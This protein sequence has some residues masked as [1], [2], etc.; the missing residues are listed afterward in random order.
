MLGGL[1]DIVPLS[2]GAL[3]SV[4]LGDRELARCVASLVRCRAGEL[5]GCMQP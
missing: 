4:G 2:C 1:S 5:S 3:A